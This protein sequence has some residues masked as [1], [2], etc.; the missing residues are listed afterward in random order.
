MKKVFLYNDDG[1]HSPSEFTVLLVGDTDDIH[2]MYEEFKSKFYGDVT[3][4][5]HDI[6]DF[7][8]WME[9]NYG[10]MELRDDEDLLIMNV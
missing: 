6:D 10:A 2:S 3:C 7:V 4:G 9:K 1:G 5:Y 8:L